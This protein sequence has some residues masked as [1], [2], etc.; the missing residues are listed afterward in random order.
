MM[1]LYRYFDDCRSSPRVCVL[2]IIVYIA[3]DTL[4]TFVFEPYAVLP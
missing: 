2:Y 3:D 4:D 1:M